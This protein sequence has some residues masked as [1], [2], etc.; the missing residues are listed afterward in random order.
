[1]ES[2]PFDATIDIQDTTAVVSITGEVDLSTAPLLRK[3]LYSALDDGALR[4]ILD[5]AGVSFIDST[6]LGVIV[7]ALKRVSESGGTLAVRAPIRP[8]RRVFEVTGL[9]RIIEIIDA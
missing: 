9:D 5:F 3:S 2:T 7:G 4:L 1:M 8:T 6:G